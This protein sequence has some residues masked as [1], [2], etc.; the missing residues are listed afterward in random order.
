MKYSCRFRCIDP[1]CGEVLYPGPPYR[2]SETPMNLNRRA[3]LLGEHNFEVFVKEL[4]YT[5]DQLVA[6][7]QAGAV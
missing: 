2:F 5:P 7:A 1:A 3:P 6:L 4:G